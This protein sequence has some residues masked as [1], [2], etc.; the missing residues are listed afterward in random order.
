MTNFE[1]WQTKEYQ[2]EDGE[3]LVEKWL[4]GLP[5][6]K[7]A[8]ILEDIKRLELYGPRHKPGF[9]EKM[10]ENISY[11]RTRHGN[12]QFRTFWFQWYERVAVLTHG[13]Q[14][15]QPKADQKEIKRAERYRNDWIERFGD[16]KE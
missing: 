15:D 1:E 10:T 12:D 2:T 3:S 16:R 4:E 14:K 7:A 6:K 13:Y 11:I 5:P 8:K 9:S